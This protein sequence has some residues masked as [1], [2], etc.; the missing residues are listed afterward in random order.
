MLAS[1]AF[2]FESL[3]YRPKRLRSQFTARLDASKKDVAATVFG[4]SA[5]FLVDSLI[6][7]GPPKVEGF[8]EFSHV[9]GLGKC[10]AALRA[11]ARG[12][13]GGSVP[14]PRLSSW[15]QKRLLADASLPMPCAEQNCNLRP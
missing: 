5:A 14:H 3:C 6:F 8:S 15:E 7:T 12:V 4:S 1:V 10:G 9:E 13:V 11:G 2:F